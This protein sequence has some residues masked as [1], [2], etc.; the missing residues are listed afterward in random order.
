MYTSEQRY[1]I[2]Q[3]ALE[4]QTPLRKSIFLTPGLF[5]GKLC[6]HLL[7]ADVQ[8][9]PAFPGISTLFHTWI[10][11]S[12]LLTEDILWRWHPISPCL[13]RLF[14]YRCERIPACNTLDPYLASPIWQRSIPL[15]LLAA[16][17]TP[18]L[19]GMRRYHWLSSEIWGKRG[20]L[21]EAYAVI[22]SRFSC[23]AGSPIVLEEW[24]RHCAD[25]CCQAHGNRVIP[26]ES[27]QGVRARES[28]CT[29]STRPGPVPDSPD[30]FFAQ[31]VWL[32]VALS[33]ANP[34]ECQAPASSRAV[35]GGSCLD[36]RDVYRH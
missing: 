3:P 19:E 16:R 20:R 4:K 8:K 28:T 26:G 33:R 9:H 34:L 7:A 25:V 13:S 5:H 15:P 24:S 14:Q 2:N 10:S 18:G 6:R 35:W 29:Q 22:Y 21:S 27:T 17:D 23:E 32:T 36:R 11:L 12:E 1:H 31:H 30:A